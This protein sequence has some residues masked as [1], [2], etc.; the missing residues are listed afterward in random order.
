VK[1]LAFVAILLLGT[2]VAVAQTTPYPT[3]VVARVSLTV[4]TPTGVILPTTIF[5]PE[6]D[7]LFRI[8]LYEDQTD[9]ITPCKPH[10]VCGHLA[11]IFGYTDDRGRQQSLVPVPYFQFQGCPCGQPVSASAIA[12]VKSGTPIRYAVQ[13]FGGGD[14]NGSTYELFLTVEQ[15][16]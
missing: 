10:I 14:D 16:Q 8:T 2:I 3:Q 15:L 6:T 4:D 1:K 9:S 13:P 5:T 7:G 12:R 11:P